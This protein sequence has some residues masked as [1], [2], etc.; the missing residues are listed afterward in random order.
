[1]KSNLHSKQQ[2]QNPII[3]VGN[4]DSITELFE[5]AESF[6]RDAGKSVVNIY[7]NILENPKYLNLLYLPLEYK[8]ECWNRIE[9]WVKDKCKYQLPLFH[10][11]LETLKN[12]CFTEIDYKET[13]TT[14]FEFNELLD[15]VQHTKLVDVNPELY[16][17]R[18]KLYDHD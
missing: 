10:S 17:L 18:D 15:N 6:N 12:K 8:I 7:L 4:L 5:Y 11:Q 16:L 13:L 1:L 9:S 2:Q 3:K 14:F